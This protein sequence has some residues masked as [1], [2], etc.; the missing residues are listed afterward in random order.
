MSKYYR[1]VDRLISSA[2]GALWRFS[3]GVSFIV[4]VGLKKTPGAWRS[5][6]NGNMTI[7]KM[8]SVRWISNKGSA[9]NGCQ[10]NTNNPRVNAFSA[11]MSA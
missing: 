6:L 11:T 10:S 4:R 2:H 7:K 8:T 9:G 1:K 5:L 3:R